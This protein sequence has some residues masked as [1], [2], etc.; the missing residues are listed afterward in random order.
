MSAVAAARE[1]V[2]A[3]RERLAARRQEEVELAQALAVVEADDARIAEEARLD[4]L[5]RR[6]D[7]YRAAETE[8]LRLRNKG[9]EDFIAYC[10]DART[11]MAARNALEGAHLSVRH[12]AANENEIPRRPS[13]MSA[14][15]TADPETKGR[16]KQAGVTVNDTS[17]DF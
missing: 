8:Y 3:A 15:L 11:A 1:K 13:R 16:L 2:A 5:E 6:L 10:T 4:E 14:L 17:L 7:V 12:I 9:I